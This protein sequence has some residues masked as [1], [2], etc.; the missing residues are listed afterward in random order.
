MGD[1]SKS[2]MSV[3]LLVLIF[4]PAW[5]NLN[6]SWQEFSFWW[7]LTSDC[8]DIS[9]PL[10]GDTGDTQSAPLKRGAQSFSSFLSGLSPLWCPW[11]VPVSGW[12]A[13]K[14]KYDK[15]DSLSIVDSSSDQVDN[16]DNSWHVYIGLLLSLSSLLLYFTM[17]LHSP[18]DINRKW[19]YFQSSE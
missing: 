15:G 14:E 1:F 9:Q 6:D 4:H 8:L 7:Q 11:T 12:V 13:A 3:R 16:S 17:N 10:T 18:E 5:H 2:V 19:K